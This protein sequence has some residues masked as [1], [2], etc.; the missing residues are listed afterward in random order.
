MPR[1]ARHGAACGGRIDR[2]GVQTTAMLHYLTEAVAEPFLVAEIVDRLAVMLDS[3]LQALAGPKCQT[4]KVQEPEKYAF[5]PK[6]LLTKITDI[7]LHLAPDP[8]PEAPFVRAVAGDERFF[9]AALF[10]SAASIMRKHALR[11]EAAI[12]QLLKFKECVEVVVRSRADAESALSDIPEEFLGKAATC[13]P[14]NEA[15]R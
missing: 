14:C 10:D 7:Y 12:Q 11:G 9:Q 15:D 3:N 8:T 1:G 6:T 5:E 4:L 2:G 13:S